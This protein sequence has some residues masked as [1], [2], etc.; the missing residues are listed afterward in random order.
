LSV[1]IRFLASLIPTKEA[2]SEE[3]YQPFIEGV[4]SSGSQKVSGNRDATRQLK[5]NSR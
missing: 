2:I 3:W 1:A 4:V 5:L